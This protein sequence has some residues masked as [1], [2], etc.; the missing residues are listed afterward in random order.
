MTSSARTAD[1]LVELEQQRPRLLGS[2]LG[3][4]ELGGGGERSARPNGQADVAGGGDQRLGGGRLL[5]GAA[6]GE[7]PQLQRAHGDVVDVARR[8]EPSASGPASASAC[9]VCPSSARRIRLA[10]R[11]C[12]V[13]SVIPRR[14][15]N[16]IPSRRRR[17]RPAAPG[18]PDDPGEVAVDDGGLAPLALLQREPERPAHVFDPVRV[19]QPAAGEAAPVERECRLGEAELGGERERP[20]GGRDR[21]G[22]SASEVRRPAM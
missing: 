6:F 20:L 19:P 21:L 8:L 2:V 1:E 11:M 22:V 12:S 4:Q 18:T 16:A 15:Q 13:T 17:V 5:G 14:S 9:S 3:E 10:A 7:Q